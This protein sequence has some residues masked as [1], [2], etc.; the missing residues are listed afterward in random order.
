MKPRQMMIVLSNEGSQNP[1][2]PLW[3]GIRPLLGKNWRDLPAR[4][5]KVPK[6]LRYEPR[7]Y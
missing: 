1:A 7:S 4:E 5:K 3:T 2:N 6:N